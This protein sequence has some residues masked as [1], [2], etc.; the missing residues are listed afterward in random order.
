MHFRLSFSIFT[1]LLI[2]HDFSCTP[3]P[4]TPCPELWPGWGGGDTPYA[5]FPPKAKIS[6]VQSFLE[7]A[8]DDDGIDLSE[9]SNHDLQ[10]PW[11]EKFLY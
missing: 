3:P 9:N 2:F 7:G 5:D 6:L 4:R 8:L 11:T 10:Y 1:I